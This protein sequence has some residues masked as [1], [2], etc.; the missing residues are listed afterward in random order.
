MGLNPIDIESKAREYIGTPWHHR[1][2]KKGVGVDCVG[3]LV[4]VYR[5]LGVEVFDLVE[6]SLSDHF[7]LLIKE[8][9]KHGRLVKSEDS[10]VA[11]DIVI[12][13][14]RDMHNHC[15]I[16]TSAGTFIHS[17]SSPAVMQVMESKYTPY[18]LSRVHSYIRSKEVQ[19]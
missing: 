5:E 11:G 7:S 6:Y 16:H 15:G 1:G 13:R 17:Y 4:C 14:G 8:V 2:R 3:L 19:L 18:W 10:P 12:F 9:L